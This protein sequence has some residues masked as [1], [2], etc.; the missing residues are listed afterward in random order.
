[1]FTNAVPPLSIAGGVLMPATIR[2]VRELPAFHLCGWRI[3][4][5]W[6]LES[7]AQLQSLESEGEV[8]LL[9]RLFEQQQLE[10]SMLTSESALEQRRSGLAEHEI[11]GWGAMEL[12][13][14]VSRIRVRF[15][16]QRLR[17]NE[18]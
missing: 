8:A 16:R 2:T 1:M 11:G 4:D 10:H 7:P 18:L 13:T 3:L 5:R 12:K 15:T 9:G 14:N 6:A 17:I